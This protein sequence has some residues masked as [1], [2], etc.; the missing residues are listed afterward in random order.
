MKLTITIQLE[1]NEK[2]NVQNFKEKLFETLK[3]N[4]EDQRKHSSV[5]K[6]I[7]DNT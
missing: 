2:S 1:D 3:A 4:L 5:K 6:P 7:T